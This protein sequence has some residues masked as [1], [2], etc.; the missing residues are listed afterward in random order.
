MFYLDLWYFF[1]EINT[2]SC[3]IKLY[4]KSARQAGMFLET[5][6]SRIQ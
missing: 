1:F 4:M 5:Y 2:F 6:I 3:E